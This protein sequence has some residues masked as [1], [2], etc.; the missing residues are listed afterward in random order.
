MIRAKHVARSKRCKVIADDGYFAVEF[1][2]VLS[3]RNELDAPEIAW[4]KDR[5]LSRHER[6]NGLTKNYN[7]LTK[8]FHHDRSNS[9]G[10][11]SSVQ[12]PR[13]KACVE[14]VCV[15]IQYEL[16]LGITSLLDPYPS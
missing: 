11:A 12:H 9:R 8:M 2:D 3:F 5:S 16:D 10:R 7:A 4:Y 15:S 13:H 6:F 1:M 14:A